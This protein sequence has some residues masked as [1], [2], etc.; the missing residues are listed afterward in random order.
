MQI[1]KKSPIPVYYQLKNLL[2]KKIQSG[3]YAEGSLI[4]SERELG[5][6]L[7]ISRMTVRQALNQLVTEGLLYR[8]KGRGT[9]VATKKLEQ[10]NNMSF[11]DTVRKKGMTP[12]TRVLEFTRIK[13]A[14]DIKTLLEL[15]EQDEI[16][17]I[18]RVRYANEQPVAIEEVFIPVEFCPGLE[19]HDLT[20]SL[21]RLLREEYSY[22]IDFIDNT[23]EAAKPTKEEKE[24]LDIPAGV[25][26]L[27]VSGTSYAAA[28]KK[29]FYERDVYRSDLF[30]YSV[31]IYMGRE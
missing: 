13:E 7:G 3:E 10:R 20:S 19:K 2:Q 17:V 28:G 30:N 1:D 25:P 29:L 12:S 18:K 14:F 4:P 8:E 6:S 5:D 31:R 23:M 15:E 16:H 27:R 24:L 26:V 21:Y 22:T 9:F 11:S